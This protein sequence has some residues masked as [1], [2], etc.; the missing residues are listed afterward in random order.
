MGDETK[1]TIKESVLAS[2]KIVLTQ[3][4]QILFRLNKHDPE[5]IRKALDYWNDE[6]R[7]TDAIVEMIRYFNIHLQE[8]QDYVSKHY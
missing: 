8:I 7:N 5:T 4:G 1:P 6:Y 2:V 3:E